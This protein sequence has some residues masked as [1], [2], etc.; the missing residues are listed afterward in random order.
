MR[1]SSG[2]FFRFGFGQFGKDVYF[3]HFGFFISSPF[4]LFVRLLIYIFIASNNLTEPTQ[5]KSQIKSIKPLHSR[6]QK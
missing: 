1:Y 6:Q 2:H 5:F 4:R 3:D